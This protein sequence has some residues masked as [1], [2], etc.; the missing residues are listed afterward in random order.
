M[1]MPNPQIFAK[2]LWVADPSWVPKLGWMVRMSRD[3]RLSRDLPTE[4]V[5]IDSV[6]IFEFL[7][8]SRDKKK[9]VIWMRS[10]QFVVEIFWFEKRNYFSGKDFFQQASGSLTQSELPDWVGIPRLIQTEK[11]DFLCRTESGFPD[12]VGI[13]TH[14]DIRPFKPLFTCILMN[15]G[16][17]AHR[18][19]YF[20]MHFRLAASHS[21][22][23]LSSFEQLSYFSKFRFDFLNVSEKII[24]SNWLLISR[25]FDFVI[26]FIVRNFNLIGK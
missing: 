18:R 15:S 13:P 25:F 9:K 12:S 14:S 23:A 26:L 24:W 1:K 4:S 22:W 6:G 19:A 7:K 5:Q 10:A 11:E 17:R 20:Q 16:W 3:F 21:A 2:I 8:N